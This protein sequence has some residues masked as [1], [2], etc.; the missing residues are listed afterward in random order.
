MLS[1]DNLNF[2]VCLD[3]TKNS[4]YFSLIHIK[5]Q[6]GQIHS[7]G[8]RTKRYLEPYGSWTVIR[9]LIVWPTL[10]HKATLRI[11]FV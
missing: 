11:I 1:Q 7:A 9:K 6:F 5:T 2:S 4:F 10:A 8:I 3:L